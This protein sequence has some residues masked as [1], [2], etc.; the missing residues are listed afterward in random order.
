[1]PE[2][3]QSSSSPEEPSLLEEHIAQSVSRDR[4]RGQVNSAS[5]DATAAA[6]PT[7]DT[8]S[9][10]YLYAANATIRR[11]SQQANALPAPARPPP[12][13]A[14]TANPSSSVY[15]SS[16]TSADFDSRAA[17][18]PPYQPP[19]GHAYSTGAAMPHSSGHSRPHY[20]Y[21]SPPQPHLPRAKSPYAYPETQSQVNRH[22][23]NSQPN[24]G[25]GYNAYFHGPLQSAQYPHTLP[26]Q[27][28]APQ[29][30]HSMQPSGYPPRTGSL[31]AY[32]SRRVLSAEEKELRRKVS[33]S[34]IEKRRRERT[35]A[36]LRSLQDMVPGLP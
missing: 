32:Y 14:T 11:P 8:S 30:Y 33:H 5:A 25:A 22:Y 27:P 18:R 28:R 26:H 15:F 9:A 4:P 19:S 16:A 7:G 2:L 6:I 23:N 34:A 1:M 12:P 20:R 3:Y 36:V 10:P 21:H 31:P 13:T 24:Q 35:N 29:P 17:T